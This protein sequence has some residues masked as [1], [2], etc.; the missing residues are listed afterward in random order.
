MFICKDVTD[1]YFLSL[2]WD[3]NL[4]YIVTK[5][6]L[7]DGVLEEQNAV[8][9]TPHAAKELLAVLGQGTHSFHGLK[10][11]SLNATAIAGRIAEGL[12]THASIKPESR[13]S[14]DSWS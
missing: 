8:S 12:R 14:P 4:L 6:I 9:Y 1:G 5:K 10:V 2:Y 13:I 3:N 11:D 7:A